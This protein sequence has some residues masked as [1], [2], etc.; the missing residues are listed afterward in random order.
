MPGGMR[1]T[2]FFKGARLSSH[3]G[4]EIPWRAQASSH[5]CQCSKPHSAPGD[6]NQVNSTIHCHHICVIR[7][8]TQGT[9]YHH[10]GDTGSWNCITW[11]ISKKRIFYHSWSN[12]FQ[13]SITR[14][15]CTHLSVTRFT[16]LFHFKMGRAF[17]KYLWIRREILNIIILNNNAR[18]CYLYL[19]GLLL[20]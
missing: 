1:K 5:V 14:R 9:V 17:T 18:H 6:W 19:G 15:T 13:F 20:H 12:P 16:L 7:N 3:I 2:T 8:L 10:H 4:E 11:N